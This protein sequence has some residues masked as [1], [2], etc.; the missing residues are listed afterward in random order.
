MAQRLKAF[1]FIALLA[2]CISSPAHAEVDEDAYAAAEAKAWDIVMTVS[3]AQHVSDVALVPYINA[4][5]N[6]GD[7]S[8]AEWTVYWNERER[9]HSAEEELAAFWKSASETEKKAFLAVVQSMDDF[10]LQWFAIPELEKDLATRLVP[11]RETQFQ[12][13]GMNTF[14]TLPPAKVATMT[15]T[16]EETVE[17]NGSSYPENFYA[18]T[19]DDGPRA[20]TTGSI[21]DSLKENGVFAT[22]FQVGQRAHK[23]WEDSGMTLFNR[24]ADEGHT[25]A[26][27]SWS[28]VELPKQTEAKALREIVD[29]Q[30]E[31]H[32]ITGKYPLYF[33]F[34]FGSR[35]ARLKEI[36]REQK[37]VSAMW[38]IDTLDWK[39][40]DPR[41][42]AEYTLPQIEAKGRGVILM[43][44][45]HT[46]TAAFVPWLL[47]QLRR[48]EATFVLLR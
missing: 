24:L 38:N 3:K 4:L 40:K 43:H 11:L 47:E 31:L 19:F 18:L 8:D 6:K 14:S 46:Q 30:D 23:E 42:I 29:T 33:R 35:S 48:R 13:L 39:Y 44:D 5:K 17:F 2:L 20:E 10:Q 27:H 37:L 36:T 28:H 12:A 45:I 7:L 22:F 16:P 26:N 9:L 1:A 25:L 34:P 15:Y 32:R 21:L 41:Q